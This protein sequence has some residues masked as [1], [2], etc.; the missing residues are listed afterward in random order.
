MSPEVPEPYSSLDD[1]KLAAELVAGQQEALSVLFKRYSGAVFRTAR[2]ILGDPGEAEEV[3]QQVFL[4]LYEHVS[5][6]DPKKGSFTSWLLRRA[7]FR[8]ADRRDQLNTQRFYDWTTIHEANEPV[9]PSDNQPVYRQEIDPLLEELLDR[10]SARHRRVIRLICL[11]GLTAA[12]AAEEMQCTSK[13]V[14]H[15]LYDGLS[16]LRSV[17]RKNGLRTRRKRG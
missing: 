10:L 13:V 7:K 14:Q 15:L 12:E 8:A 16:D 2:R 17:A 3:V 5:Q 4:E 9:S 6:F 11:E 1:N